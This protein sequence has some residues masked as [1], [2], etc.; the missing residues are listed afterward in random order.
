MDK[1]TAIYAGSFDPATKG[2][3]S[4]INEAASMFGKLVV[5]VGINPD[6]HYTFTLEERVKMLEDSVVNLYSNISVVSFPNVY[7]ANFAQQ[8]G[9]KVIVRGIRSPADLDFEMNMRNI[10]K[11]INPGIITVCLFPPEELIKVSS[12]TV[13][14]L[15]GPEGWEQVVSRYVSEPVLN[16]LKEKYNVKPR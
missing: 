14:G 8:I 15:V 12:S 4:I 7:L 1:I 13:K 5:A 11:D 9:A 2:H 10:N 3:L 6:K 16:M